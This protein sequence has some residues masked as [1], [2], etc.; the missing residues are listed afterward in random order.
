VFLGKF[1]WRRSSRC[2]GV[3]AEDA[4]GGGCAANFKLFDN[5]IVKH[6]FGKIFSRIIR[7]KNTGKNVI[8]SRMTRIGH[9]KATRQI[10]KNTGEAKNK[11]YCWKQ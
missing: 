9:D 1:I 5:Q 4:S 7:A 10:A 8:A 2:F 6:Q 3:S 11:C